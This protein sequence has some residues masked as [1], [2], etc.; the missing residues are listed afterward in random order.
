MIKD[1]INY[2][3]DDVSIIP[4]I[5]G[6]NSRSECNPMTS[7]WTLPIFCAPMTA[8]CD[9]ENYEL[10]RKNGIIPMLPRTVKFEYR[11]E[12]C[13]KVWCAFGLEEFKE[14]FVEGPILNDTYRYVCIDV[15]NGHMERL[16]ELIREAKKRNPYLKIM[17]GNVANPWTYMALAEAG[18]DFVRVGIGGGACCL[19]S[20]NTGVHFPMASLLE[21]CKFIKTTNELKAGIV[22]DG[23]ID[24]YGKAIKALALGADYVMIGTMLA[25]CFESAAE[26]NKL[27][28]D[29]M[30]KIR[31]ILGIKDISD[32]NFVP[33]WKSIIY[34]GRNKEEDKIKAI[35]ESKYN[36][37][38]K[39]IYGMSTPQ[40]QQAIDA[41]KP[42]RPT[43]GLEREIPIEYT[44]KQFSDNFKAYLRSAMAYTDCTT[45]EQFQSGKVTL[46][47]MNNKCYNR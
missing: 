39:I 23:G 36:G 42:I 7:S 12:L 33:Y 35:E 47:V 1:K 9:M 4:A 19:T 40:A 22:A 37:F 34:D 41:S 45:L 14:H 6:L 8:V 17:A 2:S 3:L 31:N 29:N 46:N 5:T 25:K 20:T 38:K 32:I 18:A 15:A 30:Y 26:P 11:M 27:L 21:Q 44:V 24:D 28:L 13:T 10:F 43:E 16:L